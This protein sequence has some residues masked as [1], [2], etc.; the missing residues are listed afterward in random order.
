MFWLMNGQPSPPASK[1]AHLIWRPRCIVLPTPNQTIAPSTTLLMNQRFPL[2]PSRLDISHHI[3]SSRMLLRDIPARSLFQIARHN[4][5]SQKGTTSR[6]FKQKEHY[7]EPLHSWDL[8]AHRKCQRLG[9]TTVS[10]ANID[11]FLIIL[12]L[13]FSYTTSF[14]ST[15]LSASFTRGLG[16][17]ATCMVL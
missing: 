11:N 17:I 3:H 1:L 6:S 5:P 7:K 13:P 16:H 15:V 9:R 12:L 14:S 10:N 8:F 2:Y 4:F